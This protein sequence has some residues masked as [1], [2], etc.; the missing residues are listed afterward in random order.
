MNIEQIRSLFPITQQAIYL[1]SASQAPL[2]TLVNDRL[3]AHLR[4]EIIPWQKAFN[5]DNIRVCS[6]N[7]WVVV[8][9]N[10][11]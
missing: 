6:P 7:F 9:K 10:M 11:L 4:T 2:N 5:R 8:P 3:Q 1:N